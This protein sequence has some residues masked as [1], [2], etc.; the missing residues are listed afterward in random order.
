[1]NRDEAGENNWIFTVTCNEDALPERCNISE[2]IQALSAEEVK[3]TQN[4]DPAISSLG[5]E[6]DTY[7]PET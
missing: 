3:A 5:S 4:A 2:P 7:P 6:K 1:M